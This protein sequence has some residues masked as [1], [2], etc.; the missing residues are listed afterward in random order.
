[1]SSFFLGE[2]VL[3]DILLALTHRGRG[4][5]DVHGDVVGGL[6]ELLAL[7]DEVGLGGQLD[8]HADDG[9]IGL[10]VQVGADGP[11]RSGPARSRFA[12]SARPFSRRMLL[13]P[14]DVAVGLVEGA[15]GVHH[16]GAGRLAESL[17]VLGGDTR[18][19]IAPP[20]PRQL[21]PA[22]SAACFG[23]LAALAACEQLR[24][25]CLGGVRHASRPAAGTARM[26]S[27][28]PGITMS[29]CRDHSWCRRAQRSGC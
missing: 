24:W 1:M 25:P 18:L 14:L 19:M 29:T 15:L 21:Q 4:S 2:D 22:A 28:L 9:T 8:Q 7:G 3:G 6:L 12:A 16:P 10:D 5:G 26:A 17:D 23:F 11:L 27:S 13:G 20:W